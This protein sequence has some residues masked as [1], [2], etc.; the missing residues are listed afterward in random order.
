MSNRSK[1]TEC[2]DHPRG[3]A[4][5]NMM[6]PVGRL[7]N[8]EK[9]RNDTGFWTLTVPCRDFFN[10]PKTALLRLCLCV[11]LHHRS[12]YEAPAG[13]IEKVLASTL[14]NKPWLRFMIGAWVKIVAIN[15]RV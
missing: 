15:I 12:R 3:A 5:A 1:T 4:D 7:T 2:P 9:S 8:C 11:S 14:L 6:S 13:C 10:A